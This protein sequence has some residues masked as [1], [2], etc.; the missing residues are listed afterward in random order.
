M[1]NLGF[2]KYKFEN[3]VTGEDMYTVRVVPYSI[4]DKESLISLACKDSNIN[5]QDMAMAFSALSQAIESF[6]LQGH[7]VT[8]DGLGNFRLTC[9]TGKWYEKKQKWV[10]G[11]A[12]SMDDVDVNNIKGVYLRFRPCTQLRNE[13][14]RVKYFDV[15]KSLFGGTIGGYDYTEVDKTPANKG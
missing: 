3:Q 9:K 13:M 8:L 12:D 6:V 4:I 7:S 5:R 1:A 10:S 11:G 14:K 2:Y 15:T